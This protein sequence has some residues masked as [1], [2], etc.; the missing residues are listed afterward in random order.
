MK[1]KLKQALIEANQLVA[2]FPS[3]V[4]QTKLGFNSLAIAL[5]SDTIVATSQ[6]LMKKHASLI[7]R[8]STTKAELT[9]MSNLL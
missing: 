9:E 8:A 5:I 1:C 7:A 2:L 6:A 3:L 4:D